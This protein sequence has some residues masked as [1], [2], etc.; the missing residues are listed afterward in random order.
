M[1]FDL[2]DQVVE[3][4]SDRIV[5][6]KNVT[7]AEEYLQDHFPGFPILPGVLMIEALVQASR[8]LLRERDPALGRHVL[9][10][11]R[12]LK[13]GSLVRPGDSLRIEV[14]LNKESPEGVFGFKGTGTV[15]RAGHDADQAP[16]A[17]S[18]RFSMRA[19]SPAQIGADGA[20]ASG[21]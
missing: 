13:Y 10:E 9:G 4:D 8:R 11:V 2:V 17:V 3:I 12:A 1:H 18:G 15:L 7:M 6:L 21:R 14:S 20:L 16:Q 19:P 5:T